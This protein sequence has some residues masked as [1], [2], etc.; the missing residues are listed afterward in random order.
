MSRER[1]FTLI[2]LMI[3]VAIIGILA[4]IALPAY[5]DY[6]RRARAAEA[7]SRLAEARVKMEQFFQDRRTYDGACVAGTIAP[8]IERTKAFT[9]ACPT[10]TGTGYVITATGENNMAGF[11][12]T[13]TVSGGETRST[14]ITGVPGWT[15][16]TSCWVLQKGGQC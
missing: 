4:S 16:S 5:T 3:V 15:G 6:I 2:E 1:G 9:F 13:L 11:V 7:V 8:P 10:R 12:Y 14:T